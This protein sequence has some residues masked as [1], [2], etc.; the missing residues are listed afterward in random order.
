MKNAKILFLAFLATLA[1]TLRSL[2]QDCWEC[3]SQIS[4][5][6]NMAANAGAFSELDNNGNLY[7]FSD[8]TG[9]ITIRSRTI[10]YGGNTDIVLMKM[11]AETCDTL[12]IRVVNGVN[13]EAA[14]DMKLDDDG[15]IYITGGFTV[16]ANFNGTVITSPDGTEDIFL[17]KYNPEGNLIFARN[18]GYGAGIQRSSAMIVDEQD[19]IAMLGIYNTQITFSTG[20]SFTG[21]AAF[22]NFFA[23]FSITD[24]NHGSIKNWNGTD[25][26]TRLNSIDVACT[27]GYYIGG[28]FYGTLTPPCNSDVTSTNQGDIL[29]SKVDKDGCVVPGWIYTYGSTG[30]VNY[31]DVLSS[32]SSDGDCNIYYTGSFFRTLNMD[33]SIIQ[34]DGGNQDIYV[35]KKNAAGTLQWVKR[36][37]SGSWDEGLSIS[38][39]D[40]IIAVGG[41]FRGDLVWGSDTVTSEI[42]ADDDSFVGII[43]PDGKPFA[44]YN[45]HGRLSRTLD[46]AID[47]YHNFF[48]T[49]TFRGTKID[50]GCDMSLTKTPPRADN[51]RDLWIAR[52]GPV[53]SLEFLVDSITC[54]G[55]NDGAIDM[56]VIGNLE[57]YTY[58]WE[59]VS[60]GCGITNPNAE[61]LSGLCAGVYKITVGYS[62]GQKIDTVLVSGPAQFIIDSAKVTQQVTQCYGDCSGEIRV[63]ARGGTGTLKY[64]LQP[65]NIVNTTGIFSNLCADTYT[66]T[67]S[68][69]HNCSL[70]SQ[71]LTVIQPPS[72]V[73][74]LDIKTDITCYGLN[75]GR[76]EMNGS[77][78]TGPL[79]FTLNPGNVTNDDGI[80]TGLAP[81]SYTICLTDA[82]TCGPVCVGP[83]DILEPDSLQIVSVTQTHLLCHGGANGEI[84][85]TAQ[86]GKGTLS[87][88]LTPGNI[89]NTTGCFT[90]LV[91]GTYCVTVD[92]A[93]SCGPVDTCDIV[94]LQP[95]MVSFT[96]TQTDATCFD[97]CDGSITVSATGGNGEYEYSR[98]G[99]STWQISNVFS[100]L[101][102]NS[103]TIRVKDSYGCLSP[104]SIVQITEPS[105]VS[106]TYE[107]TDISC[108][109]EHDASVTIT[110]SGGNGTY[111]YSINCGSSWQDLPVFPGLAPGTY[112]LLVKDWRECHSDPV[113]MEIVAPEP[114]TIADIDSTGIT[115]EGQVNGCVYVRAEGGNSPYIYT[116]LPGG[117]QNTSGD[118]C[119]LVPGTYTVSIDDANGCGP[120]V[121]RGITVPAPEDLIL[122]DAI[123]PNGDQVNDEWNIHVINCFPDAIV[124]IF[125][126]W[127]T[128]VFESEAG[129]P[130]P[131]N[132]KFNGKD[133]PAGTYYY[134]IDLN[135]DGSVQMKGTVNIIK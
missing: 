97:V 128:R 28:T 135:G 91:A 107:I 115:C 5:T 39:D 40:A 88:T 89:T 67:V 113:N 70:T 86:G 52:H 49:G 59:I 117:T 14:R 79:Q 54:Y 94:L 110:A 44:I 121:T 20:K 71:E 11:N 68:D 98:D 84:C 119:G 29:L 10:P 61:D 93:N 51:L 129:Y 82:N 125:S 2:P 62:G 69:Y 100:D 16:S 37:G 47:A 48:A 36:F 50:F 102:D 131:W 132:G 23:K 112:C 21:D 81:G 111:L 76:I 126:S 7:I 33:G 60:G 64:T 108:A 13:K 130:V 74:L 87:Y 35:A 133:L 18:V 101:C 58:L 57:P 15:N 72:L 32:L 41:F 27:D 3:L 109:G 123:T 26:A 56:T 30:P 65:G 42:P 134:V 25:G 38:A 95:E 99:G 9:P 1:G 46:V 12:W 124:R 78:G 53:I 83:I 66:V 103:Y 22:D 127:G 75:N 6:A 31:H 105:M 116:I 43:T 85:V 73:L 17:A 77:G 90:G 4:S 55:G 92:D 106:F 104:D 34:A 19:S 63:Y 45:P 118:F 96:K 122:Y 114:L 24:G 120:I 8:Y 80:F